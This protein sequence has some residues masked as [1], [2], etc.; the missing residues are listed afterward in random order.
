MDILRLYHTVKYLR[1]EQVY[2]RLYYKLKAKFYKYPGVPKAA[3][4]AAGKFPEIP[5]PTRLANH[6]YREAGNMF[7]LLNI[8][9]SFGDR[10]DWN[11]AAYGKLWTYNLNYFEW[12]EDESL[13]VESRL[14]TMLDYAENFDRLQDGAEPYPISLRGMAWIK[15]MSQHGIQESI[16]NNCLYKHYH[17]LAAFPEYQLQANHLLE[18]GLSL[19]FAGHYFEED[20][21]YKTGYSIVMK[22]LEEQILPD[23]G[24]CEQSPM[25]QCILLQHLMDC[26]MLAEN[27]DRYRNDGLPQVMRKKAAL[28]C[29]WLNAFCYKDGSY[30]MFGDSA[31]DV[32]PNVPFLFDYAAKLGLTIPKVK[33]RESGYRKLEAGAFEMVA[34]VGNLLPSY[35]AGHAHA[36]TL[37]FCLQV[38][39]QP[40]IVDTGISTY[41]R[42]KRRSEE[43]GTGAHNTITINGQNSSDVWAAFRT[44]ER[45]WARIL[46]ESDHQIKA[47]HDGYRNMGI[48]HQRN[49]RCDNQ[50]IIIEDHLLNYKGQDAILSLHFH[51]G[52][53]LKAV[54]GNQFTAGNIRI[55]I[56]GGYSMGLHNYLYCEGYNRLADAQC[57]RAH[58]K[59]HVKV[60][61]EQII[62]AG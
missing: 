44:G 24:Y 7:S 17:H 32:A 14:S 51:P 23:G 35:Q 3:L 34:D 9:H 42:G 25:Y 57:L 20:R 36:D 16:L 22:Q 28:M 33:L 10:I 54:G 55:T 45:A 46:S 43:R 56:D 30:A 40:F 52:I 39:G 21:F 5:F 6:K 26:I 49:M 62:Y 4:E 48:R 2:Y 41:E 50:K 58:V 61:I 8:E 13:T 60:V 53:Y 37:S 38:D 11:Y 31:N 29:G 19:L 18:N 1:F 47:E 27:S 12:L 15:F 59:E